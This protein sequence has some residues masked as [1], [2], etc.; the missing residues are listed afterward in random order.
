MTQFGLAQ[1]FV[2]AAIVLIVVHRWVTN[3]WLGEHLR[4]YKRLPTT[5]WWKQQD[6]D[7][8]VERWRRL[9]ILALVPT[10]ASFAI[11]VTLLIAAR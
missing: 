2:I 9:R 3:R 7:P 10:V 5:D 1:V 4:R 11:A 8:T 6:R